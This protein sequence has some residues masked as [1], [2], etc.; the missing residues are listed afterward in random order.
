MRESKS[1]DLEG[2]SAWLP[3]PEAEDGFHQTPSA[4]PLPTPGLAPVGTPGLGGPP[5]MVFDVGASSKMEKQ[6]E[7]RHRK[8]GAEAAAAAA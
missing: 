8:E 4:S 7:R 3:W 5:T 1:L 2:Q 6:K